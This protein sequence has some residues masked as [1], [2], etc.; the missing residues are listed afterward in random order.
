MKAKQISYTCIVT[1][2]IDKDGE[3]DIETALSK[4]AGEIEDV[5]FDFKNRLDDHTE[6]LVTVSDVEVDDD[7]F[8]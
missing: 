5:A 7:Y 6:M 1:V 8:E 4:L 2:P 3:F